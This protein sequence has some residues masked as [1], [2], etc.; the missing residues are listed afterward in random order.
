LANALPFWLDANVFVEAANRYYK[1]DRVPKFWSFLSSE[2]QEG[3]ICCP[4]AVYDELMPYKDHLTTWIR[5][6]KDKGLCVRVTDDIQRH[7]SSVADH[8]VT[9]Y[10]RHKSEEFLAGADPWIIAYALSVGGT[11]VTQESTSRKRKVRIPTVC[12]Q[13]S[14]RVFDTFQMLDWFKPKF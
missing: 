13:F 5:T 9:K 4:K 14:V 7:F 12:Q 1:F 3:S 11:V 6:R 10:P 2:I 8:V